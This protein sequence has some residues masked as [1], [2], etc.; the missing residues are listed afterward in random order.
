MHPTYL[1][2]NTDASPRVVYGSS[3]KKVGR[4]SEVDD[5]LLN[6]SLGSVEYIQMPG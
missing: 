4:P 1:M 2:K 6:R 5:K 3:T